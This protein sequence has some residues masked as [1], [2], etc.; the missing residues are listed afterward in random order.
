MLYSFY[1]FE[2]SFI[3]GGGGREFVEVSHDQ[4]DVM[5]A[6]ARYVRDGNW[7][8][9]H[10]D[11]CEIRVYQHGEVAWEQPVYPLTTV[12]IPGFT[13]FRFDDQGR[14]LGGLP[15]PGSGYEHLSKLDLEGAV[16]P[17]LVN[18]RPEEVQVTI[19]WDNL[20]WPQLEPP[21]LPQD[22]CVLIDL[23]R[24]TAN[25]VGEG[26]DDEEFDEYIEELEEELD[27]DRRVVFYGLNDL[28]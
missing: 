12:K 2:G 16:I 7:I 19:D 28:L 23:A 10:D 18:K 24:G 25:R 14:K 13:E 15:E 3:Q 27:D 20:A 9:G 17:E 11:T 21:L 5:Q 22:A 1:L 4:A 8:G 6:A 26:L